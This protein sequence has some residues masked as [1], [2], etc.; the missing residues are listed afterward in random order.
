MMSLPLKFCLWTDHGLVTP[1]MCAQDSYRAVEWAIASADASE[2]TRLLLLCHSPSNA[3]CMNKL[4]L[5]PL[6]YK[7]ASAPAW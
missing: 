2:P 3:A 6:V 4:M 5:H 1:P 7:L